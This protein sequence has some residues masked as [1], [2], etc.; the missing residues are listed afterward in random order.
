MSGEEH[1]LHALHRRDRRLASLTLDQTQTIE[2][3]VRDHRRLDPLKVQR[4]AVHT[5]RWDDL[6]ETC[7]LL[8]THIPL[9][10][11]RSLGHLPARQV[12]KVPPTLL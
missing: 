10:V 3:V 7:Y 12:L 6:S 1:E 5:D 8:Q 11:S 9:V 4:R 2:R